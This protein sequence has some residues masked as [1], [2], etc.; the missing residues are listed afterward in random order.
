MT[1]R[2]KSLARLLTRPSDFA[3]DELLGVMQ[4]FDFDLKTT[5]GS[6]RKFIHRLTGVTHFM[7]EPHPSKVLKSYQVRD[8][9][10]LLRK[11]GYIE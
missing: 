4:A 3:W 8:V 7:H 1:K 5:G 6:G 10:T 2:N 11:E 9:I